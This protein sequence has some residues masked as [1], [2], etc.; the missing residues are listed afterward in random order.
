MKI[1]RRHIYVL[2]RAGVPKLLS[3]FTRSSPDSHEI[4]MFVG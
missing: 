1:L 4:P 3:G 2:Y